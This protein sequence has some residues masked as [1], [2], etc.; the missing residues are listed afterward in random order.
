[1]TR[2]VSAAKCEDPF[3]DAAREIANG[4]AVAVFGQNRNILL[5]KSL[6]KRRGFS[7]KTRKL[8]DMILIQQGGYG[9]YLR[10]ERKEIEMGASTCARDINVG[11]VVERVDQN[12]KVV[13]GKTF[14]VV[15]IA[16]DPGH[17]GIPVKEGTDKILTV[18]SEGDVDRF[19]G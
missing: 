13:K 7:P 1:M 18:G 12:G 17:G 16:V 5:H 19:G 9:V 3:A 14:V 6:S 4:N 10:T 11:I 2:S 15:K 8:F